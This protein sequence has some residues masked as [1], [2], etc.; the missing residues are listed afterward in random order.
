MSKYEEL[1]RAYATSRKAYND[2]REACYGFAQAL[3][4]GLIHHLELPEGQI[5]FVPVNREP[6]PEAVYTLAGAMHLDDDTYWHFGVVIA[7]C[8]PSGEYPPQAALLKILVKRFDGAFAVR[9]GVEEEDSLVH[10]DHPQELLAFF[11]KV[12]GIIRDSYEQGLQQFLDQQES[13]RKIG[14]TD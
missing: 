3:V 2:Y 11:D 10:L 9:L 1:C 14:F 8:D 6:D 7:L 5:H 4:E 13:T 12:Y